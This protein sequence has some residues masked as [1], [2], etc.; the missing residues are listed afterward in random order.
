MANIEAK[1]LWLNQPSRG[2]AANK[3][4]PIILPSKISVMKQIYF[5]I[6]AVLAFSAVHAQQTTIDISAIDPAFTT[7]FEGALVIDVAEAASTVANPDVSFDNPLMGQDF[8]EAEIAFDVYNYEGVDSI[9]VLGSLIALF[10]DALGRM[11]FTNGSY[12]GFNNGMFIDA[13]L[14]DFGIDTDFLGGNQWRNVKLQFTQTGYAVYVDNELA[15]NESS[16]DVTIAGNL[17]DY[18]QI[19]D[20][21]QNAATLVIGTGSFWSDNMRPDGTFFDPQYSY[22]KNITVTPNFSTSTTEVFE[23]KPNGKLISVTYFTMDGRKVGE[24]FNNLEPGVYVK[25]EAY[26]SGQVR[27]EKIFKSTKR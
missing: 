7:T 20:F 26:D 13:N 8:T 12:L 1:I 19:I 15:Y 24:D 18:S 27:S 2:R 22:M 11:Y 6:V 25:V 23:D 4:V 16:T 9:K 14:I 5:L 21:M 10:D 3:Q 17:T